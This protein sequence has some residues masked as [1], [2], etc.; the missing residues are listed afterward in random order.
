MRDEFFIKEYRKKA[1]MADALG[2]S[3]RSREYQIVEFLHV[4]REII[5][6][7]DLR[8]GHDLLDVGCANGLMD[9]LLSGCCRSVLAVEP[10]EELATLARKNLAYYSNVR[11]Q[12]G[13]GAAIPAGE[14]SFD[15]V[16]MLEVIQMIALDEARDVVHEL[17]RVTRPGGRILFGNIPDS[18]RR[19]EFLGP[20]LE[21]VR[22]ATHLSEEQ[23]AEIIARNL[24]TTWYDPAELVAWWSAL[25]CKASHQP[26]Q[27]GIPTAD[28]R[29]HLIVSVDK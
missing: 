28:H 20:Y 21:G 10:L 6:L 11:V 8:Y 27:A 14:G 18:R 29:F 15:R 19:D 9:I 2:Q 7:L 5:R 13:H 16:L 1:A 25:G 17:R 3:G 12:A 23:K 24:K 22:L 26:L 4:A